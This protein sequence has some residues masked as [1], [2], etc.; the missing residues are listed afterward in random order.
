M[1]EAE[2]SQFGEVPC[3]GDFF[4]AFAFLGCTALSNPFGEIGVFELFFLLF[5]LE[6]FCCIMCMCPGDAGIPFDNVIPAGLMRYSSNSLKISP[7]CLFSAMSLGK[8]SM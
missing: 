4:L 5:C 3:F 1:E 2:P 8:R 6:F 7:C